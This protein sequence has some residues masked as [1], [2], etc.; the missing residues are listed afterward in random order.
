MYT[1]RSPRQLCGERI[2]SKTIL[3]L[4]QYFNQK[5]D[6]KRLDNMKVSSTQMHSRQNRPLCLEIT[7]IFQDK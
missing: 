5:P 6:V 2:A 7:E 1:L 4:K 3:Y